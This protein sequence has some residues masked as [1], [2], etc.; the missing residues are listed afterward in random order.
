MPFIKGFKNILSY[1][2]SLE[3]GM[4]GVL[5]LWTEEHS[6]DP[7]GMLQSF[8]KHLLR[9]NE[10][11]DSALNAGFTEMNKTWSCPQGVLKQDGVWW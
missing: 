3:K 9:I 4:S 5:G 2:T 6:S 11:P 7:I 8:Y 10:L 1:C